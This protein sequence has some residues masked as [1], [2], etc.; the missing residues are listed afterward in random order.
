[1]GG[2]EQ[3]MSWIHLEDM[4][5]L[6]GFCLNSEHIQ[7]PVNATAP[8]PVTNREFSK[9]LANTLS[10]P[11]LLPMPA[12]AARLMF[13]EMADE[14]LLSGQKVVPAKLEKADYDFKYPVLDEALEAVLQRS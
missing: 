2:G 11:C 5:G 1:M 10:R 8:Q 14:L 4:V 3:W 13:G 6:V 9:T 7:G 12:F